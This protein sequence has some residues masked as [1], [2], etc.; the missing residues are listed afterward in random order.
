MHIYSFVLVHF[1]VES[2]LLETK[3]LVPYKENIVLF[4]LNS[5]A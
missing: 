1:M 5:F 2:E 4:S 3:F